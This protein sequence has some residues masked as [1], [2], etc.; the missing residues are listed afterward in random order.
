MS[1]QL[2]SLGQLQDQNRAQRRD[3]GERATED[4]R[5]TGLAQ[6]QNSRLRSMEPELESSDDED[7]RL[8]NMEKIIDV[9][10]VEG[11]LEFKVLW[12]PT[13]EEDREESWEPEWRLREDKCG[14]K[15]AGF[16]SSINGKKRREELRSA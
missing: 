15:I 9:R 12:S 11:L 1:L 8:W 10:R 4:D 5:S 16:W 14:R 7:E 6:R 3:E 13:E 2:S